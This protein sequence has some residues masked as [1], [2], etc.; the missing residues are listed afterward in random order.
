[1]TDNPKPGK[2]CEC[3]CGQAIM[4]NRRFRLGHSARV[5][6]ASLANLKKGRKGWSKE[7]QQCEEDNCK[8]D[9]RTRKKCNKHY[10]KWYR[11]QQKLKKQQEIQLARSLLQSK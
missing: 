2:T 1:M 5:N 6:E 10:G 9:A 4:W 3:G 8:L 11:K 7:K